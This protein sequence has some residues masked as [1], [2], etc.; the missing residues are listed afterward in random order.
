MTEDAGRQPDPASDPPQPPPEEEL[1]PQPLPDDAPPPQPGADEGPEAAA[2]PPQ[3]EELELDTAAGEESKEPEAGPD[4]DATVVRDA[5]WP[6]EA[7]GPTG[8]GI[9]PPVREPEEEPRWAAR[10]PVRASGPPTEPEWQPEPA[11]GP[12]ATPVL[13]TIAVI[14]MLLLIGLGIYLYVH[15]TGGQPQPPVT[16][17][18]PTV[19]ATTPTTNPTTASPTPT[20]TASTT[21]PGLVTVPPLQGLDYNGALAKLGEFGLFATRVDE[22]STTVPAGE[23]I[24]TNPAP[25]QAV[26]VHSVIQV[27]VSLGGPTPTAT[28]TPTVAAT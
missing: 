6:T 11:P 1:P 28:A 25:G 7:L 23:V 15:G 22:M 16:T 26:P 19:T 20:P 27:R 3:T 13:V 4:F 17:S 10:A 24:G 14:I 18:S 2:E 5:G 12:G 21:A 8:T 9:L